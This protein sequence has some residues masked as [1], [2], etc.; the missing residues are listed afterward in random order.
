M[1]VDPVE[2]LGREVAGGKKGEQGLG[3]QNV[4]VG[5]QDMAPEGPPDADVLGDH[6]I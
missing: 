3:E 4:Y 2:S 1:P 6:L 5:D